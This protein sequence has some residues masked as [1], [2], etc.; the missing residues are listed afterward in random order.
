MELRDSNEKTVALGPDEVDAVYFNVRAAR[1][2]VHRLTVTAQ[3]AHVQ[4]AVRRAI[5]VR[6]DGKEQEISTSDAVRGRRTLRVRVPEEAV[7]G[8]GSLHVRLFPSRLSEAT[9]GLDRLMRLPHG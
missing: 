5:E 7:D 8:A 3:G 9:V 6:P 2:G 1:P 4:D